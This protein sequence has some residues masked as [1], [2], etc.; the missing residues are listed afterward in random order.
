MSLTHSVDRRQM[1]LL[2]TVPLLAALATGCAAA[3][4]Q[5][6]AAEAPGPAAEQPGPAAGPAVG[7]DNLNAVL[8]VQ[9]AVEYRATALQAYALARRALDDALADPGWTAASEQTGDYAALPP[10]IIL[11]IDETV[12]DNSYYEARL[13]LDQQAY[14]EQSWDA[15]VRQRSSTAIPGARDFLEYAVS[16]GVTVFYVTNRRAHLEDDT[17]ANLAAVGMPIEEDLDT[18]LMRD[19]RPEWSP[20]DKSPRRRHVASDYR[21]LL[22]LGD[23]MGDFTDASSG[24]VAERAAFAE[25]HRDW[26]GTRWIV[27]ANPTY[28]SF[29]GA[30][31]DNDY[32]LSNAQQVEAKMRALD[33]RR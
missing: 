27:L 13:T 29:I 18:L 28:G 15:W 33:P 20:S 24:T 30:V 9:S 16:R 5:P 6:P 32:S 3:R 2:L 31:L 11:D 22:M 23:N 25:E 12:L 7:I 8:W 10:A 21:V 19:E 17:R 14:D 26:W 1:G 4:E